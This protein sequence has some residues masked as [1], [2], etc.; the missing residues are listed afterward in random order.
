MESALD[1][2][3]EFYITLQSDKSLSHYPSNTSSDFKNQL[4]R[5]I[6]LKNDDYVVGISEIFYFAKGH[7]NLSDSG[8]ADTTSQAASSN[9]P[10]LFFDPKKKGDNIVKTFKT[11]IST[12]N[13]SKK[14][15]DIW[16]NWFTEFSMTLDNNAEVHVE[17]SKYYSLVSRKPYT[18]IKLVDPLEEYIMTLPPDTATVFGFTTTNFLPN[19]EYTSEEEQDINVFDALRDGHVLSIHVKKILT[20]EVEIEEPEDGDREALLENIVFALN[21]AKF[22]TGFL[23]M[24]DDTLDVVIYDEGVALQMPPPVCKV[25]GIP[26]GTIFREKTTRI[27]LPPF[28]ETETSTTAPQTTVRQGRVDWNFD[29]VLVLTDVMEPTVFADE[30]EPL[31]RIIQKPLTRIE[32]GE[33]HLTFSPVYYF[34]VRR[35]IF[36]SMSIRLLDD[37][38]KHL[39]VLQTHPTTVILHFKRRY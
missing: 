29:R 28:F 35:Q 1:F 27:R 21:A 20:T 25:L 11:S 13:Q 3:K 14:R 10:K 37:K 2:H 16:I 33:R 7:V 6:N 36:T 30:L 9:G 17:L 39:P 8:A 12:F 19:K 34:P 23:M 32:V 4:P 38:G 15:G 18:V 22:K 5:P 31:I 26:D 24:D